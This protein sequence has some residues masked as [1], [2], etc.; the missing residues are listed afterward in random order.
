MTVPEVRQPLVVRER[1]RNERGQSVNFHD[2]WRIAAGDGAR[3]GCPWTRPDRLRVG[4]RRARPSRL[5]G[6][7]LVRCNAAFAAALYAASC[8]EDFLQG[9]KGIL[10]ASLPRAA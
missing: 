9:V 4:L 1:K 2:R 8:P 7:A 3:Y 6:F 10:G 5:E